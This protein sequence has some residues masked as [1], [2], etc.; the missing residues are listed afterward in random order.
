MDKPRD[1]KSYFREIGFRWTPQRQAIAEALWGVAT[2]PSAEEIYGIVRRRHPG[3]SRATVYNT[4]EALAAVGQIETI[5]A[6]DGTRRFDPNPN[7]HHHLRCR[8]CGR[9]VDLPADRLPKLPKLS[10]SLRRGFLVVGY[11]IELYGICPQCARSPGQD[12]SGAAGRVAVAGENKT[13]T[14]KKES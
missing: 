7:P 8:R 13:K 10:T 2:H 12:E 6:P 14:K 5:H 4:M 11:R 9:I 1:L 3:M